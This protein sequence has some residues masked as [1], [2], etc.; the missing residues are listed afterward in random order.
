[1]LRAFLTICISATSQ[2]MTWLAACKCHITGHYP[3]LKKGDKGKGCN[4]FLWKPKMAW[5]LPINF[6]PNLQ[7]VGSRNHDVMIFTTRRRVEKVMTARDWTLISRKRHSRSDYISTR[8]DNSAVHS[9]VTPS[10]FWA[11]VEKSYW[12]RRN[13]GLIYTVIKKISYYSSLMRE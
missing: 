4:A 8:D 12:R 7:N 2:T 5:L 9:S 3:P 10:N 13:I 6:Q 11:T 1:M